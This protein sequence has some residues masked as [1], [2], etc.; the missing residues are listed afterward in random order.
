MLPENHTLLH[1]IGNNINLCEKTI[2]YNTFSQ[3]CS[4]IHKFNHRHPYIGIFYI[5]F[6]AGVFS[7]ERSA[8]RGASS[9]V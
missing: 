3:P 8:K 4:T 1:K 7:Y 6:Y 9:V 2:I 5:Y